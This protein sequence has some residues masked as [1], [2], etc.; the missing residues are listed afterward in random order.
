MVQFCHMEPKDYRKISVD[1]ETHR[2]LRIRA[3]KLGVSIVELMRRMSMIEN[4]IPEE[5]VRK[6]EPKRKRT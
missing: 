1:A 3:A 6:H 4:H 2:R 5:E